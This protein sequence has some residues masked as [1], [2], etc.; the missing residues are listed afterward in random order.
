VLKPDAVK[1]GSNKGQPA[2]PRGAGRTPGASTYTR[3]R[4]ALS[5]PDAVKLKPDAVKLKPDAAIQG[6][7]CTA[8]PSLCGGRRQALGDDEHGDKADERGGAGRYH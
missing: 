5:Q 1:T 7:A 6:S 3:K 4:L 2:P 8:L